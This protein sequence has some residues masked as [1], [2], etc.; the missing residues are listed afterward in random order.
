MAT[1]FGRE[2]SCTTALKPGRFV[3]GARIVAESIYRRLTTPRGVLRGTEEEANFGLDLTE[4][5]GSVSTK[6]DIAS[7]PGRIRSEILKDERVESVD[8]RV[9]ETSDAVAKSFA[10]FIEAVTTLGPFTLN[11]EVDEVT[12]ALL[13]IEVAS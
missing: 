3:S 7:L 4:L 5:I 10:V 1:D 9:V 2:V 11:I 6:T 8:V 13:G 12:A